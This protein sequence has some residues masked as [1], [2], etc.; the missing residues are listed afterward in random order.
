MMDWTTYFSAVID[1]STLLLGALGILITFIL[2]DTE[3][4]WRKFCIV[5]FSA[6]ILKTAAALI[7]QLAA[8]YWKNIPLQTACDFPPPILPVEAYPHPLGIIRSGSHRRPAD[9]HAFC[10]SDAGRHRAK[11]LVDTGLYVFYG[12]Q[13]DRLLCR[14]DP[15]KKTAFKTPIHSHIGIFAGA[16][17]C[18][19][20]RDGTD[21][22]CRSGKA[23]C[24]AKGRNR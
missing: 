9:T 10:C 24:Q 21:A 18:H 2:R 3:S 7:G 23:V 8:L 4:Q 1:L 15:Q 20:A 6:M 22:V 16:C 11:A 13:P 12:N 19:A 17:F 14:G 5:F